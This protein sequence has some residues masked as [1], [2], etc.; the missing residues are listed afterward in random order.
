MPC[1]VVDIPGHGRAHVCVRGGR[2]KRC[3]FCS[4][5][6]VEKLC[7]F[8]VGKGRTCDAGMCAKCA[9][10]VGEDRDFCPKHKGQTPAQGA[11]PL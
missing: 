7:D 10:N 3:S 6:Y 5:G 2:S 11:L 4:T 9:T 8:D 1:M